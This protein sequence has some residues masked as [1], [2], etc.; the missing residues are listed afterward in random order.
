MNPVQASNVHNYTVLET[1][2]TRSGNDDFL[3][4][5][6]LAYLSPDAPL[7][8]TTTSH[9]AKSVPLRSANYD[10]ADSTVTLIPKRR[11]SALASESLFAP[12]FFVTQG[13][14]AKTQA[15]VRDRSSPA[16]GLAD[17]DGNAINQ[18]GKPGSF[19]IT[20]T[21]GYTPLL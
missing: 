14:P 1:W 18:G 11:L 4:S 7:G 8:G 3:D 12:C 19:R 6:P 13:K 21:S 2:T 10:P 9:H 15:R 20:V 5:T 17:L 16:Q